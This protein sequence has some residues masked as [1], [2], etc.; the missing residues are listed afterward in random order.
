MLPHRD[1]GRVADDGDEIAASPDLDPQHGKAVLRVVV[2]DAFD[3]S[4]Q[5]F[6]HTAVPHKVTTP[7]GRRQGEGT[8]QT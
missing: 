6:S 1:G 3:E 5:G 7:S 4:V 2:G 8:P